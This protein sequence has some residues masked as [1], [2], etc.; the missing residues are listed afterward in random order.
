MK[1]ESTQRVVHTYSTQPNRCGW[2]KGRVQGGEA[3]GR[4]QALPEPSGQ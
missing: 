3:G 4:D 1:E 2:G